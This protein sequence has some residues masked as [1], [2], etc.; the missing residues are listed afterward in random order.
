MASKHKN[1]LESL[2]SDFSEIFGVA[3]DKIYVRYTKR[4]RKIKKLTNFLEVFGVSDNEFE[5]YF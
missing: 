2:N 5:D 3:D 4:R 1:Q